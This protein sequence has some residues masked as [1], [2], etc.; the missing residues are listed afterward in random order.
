MTLITTTSNEVLSAEARKTLDEFEA[1]PAHEY[2]EVWKTLPP[3]Q[4]QEMNGEYEGRAASGYNDL[5]K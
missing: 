5:H 3:P 1:L 2:A 4:F